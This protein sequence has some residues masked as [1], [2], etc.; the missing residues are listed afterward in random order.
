MRFH[1]S[2]RRLLLLP[3]LPLLGAEE[4]GIS[5]PEGGE[6]VTLCDPTHAWGSGAPIGGPGGTIDYA[7]ALAFDRAELVCPAP[8][9]ALGPP[10]HCL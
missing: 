2:G 8:R 10:Q 1:N 5:V 4:F 3:L 7:H 6:R 9:I